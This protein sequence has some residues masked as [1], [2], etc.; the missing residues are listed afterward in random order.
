MTEQ[1][2]PE[3]IAAAKVVLLQTRKR[4]GSWVDTP[5]N[6][7][8]DG[9]H[10]Y[11]RT[12]GRASKNKRL[13]NFPDVR[14]SPCTWSGKPT[15]GGSAATA[16]LLAGAEAD[17]AARAIDHRFPILQHVLVRAT[18]KVMRT[19]TLHYELTNFHAP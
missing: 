15:G 9:S 2:P 7:A 11:F 1:I 5:V 16:H 6:I 19:P 8:M 18:H 13:R 10:T 17:A 14:I 3:P 4:D 12:P